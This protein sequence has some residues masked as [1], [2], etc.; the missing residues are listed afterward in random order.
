[1]AYTRFSRSFL[2]RMVL[3]AVFSL[4]VPLLTTSAGAQDENSWQLI[5]AEYGFRDAQAEVTG[6]LRNLIAQGGMNGRIAV[7]NQTM[8]GDPAVGKD[9]VLHIVA[10]NRRGE[11]R[12]FTFREGNF[13]DVAMFSAHFDRQDRP[14]DWDNRGPGDRDRDRDN[15]GPGDRDHDRDLYIIRGYYGIQGRTVNVTEVLRSM[16]REGVLS[17]DVTNSNLGGDPAVGANKVLIVIY[18]FRGEEQAAAVPEGNRLTVP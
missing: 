9:K 7:T 11:Q 12:D 8:G 16:V 10:R 3:L 17:L 6:L 2:K 14:D 13:V 4:G 18:R 5:R 1:M 15:R